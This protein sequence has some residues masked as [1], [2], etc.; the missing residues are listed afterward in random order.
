[1]LARPIRPSR[2]ARN[3]TLQA[4]RDAGCTC[5]PTIELAGYYGGK[6]Q[7]HLVRHDDRCPALQIGRTILFGARGGSR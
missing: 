4:A 3:K 6:V 2:Q 5:E 7:H 1:M